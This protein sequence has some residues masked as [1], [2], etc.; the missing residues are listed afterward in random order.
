M[1]QDLFKALIDVIRL[2]IHVY[3]FIIIIRSLISWAG[4]MPPNRFTFFLRKVTDPVFRFVHKY[5]PFTI[6]GGIDISPII[7]I[8][9]LYLLINLLTRWA[10]Y[11]LLN[12]G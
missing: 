2:I 12:G 5:L 3:I 8:F 7:I 4:N 6:I 1:F 11:V 10:N 9:S